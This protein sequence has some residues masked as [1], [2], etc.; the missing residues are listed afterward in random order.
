MTAA[1]KSYLDSI[2]RLNFDEIKLFIHGTDVST[3]DTDKYILI[4]VLHVSALHHPQ[5]AVHRKHTKM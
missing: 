1:G 2:G 5:G 4:S 3:F